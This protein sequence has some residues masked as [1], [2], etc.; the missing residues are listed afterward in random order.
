[1]LD[2][3]LHDAKD[4]PSGGEALLSQ[5][6]SDQLRLGTELVEKKARIDSLELELK[7]SSK[8]N[9]GSSVKHGNKLK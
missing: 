5:T 4:F 3:E 2:L 1:M 6:C 9:F 8:A 7:K